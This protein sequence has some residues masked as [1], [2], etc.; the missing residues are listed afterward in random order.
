MEEQNVFQA[1]AVVE[2]FGHQKIAGLLTEQNIGG[3][4]FLRIEVPTTSKQPGFTKFYNP[5][6][7]YG[8]TPVDQEYATR[9]ADKINADPVNTYEHF[10]IIGDIVKNKL[11]QLAS[12]GSIIATDPKLLE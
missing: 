6:S 7:V 2:L 11:Q 8:I 4:S 9:M 3:H 12:D 10:T 1:W 5:S